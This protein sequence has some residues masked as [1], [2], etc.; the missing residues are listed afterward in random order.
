MKKLIPHLLS[1]FTT[2]R[3]A[4]IISIAVTVVFYL[5]S[6]SGDV[7]TYKLEYLLCSLVIL[8]I[9]FISIMRAN[10]DK[11]IIRIMADNITATET[12]LLDNAFDT[13]N[14]V[15]VTFFYIF[16]AGFLSCSCWLTVNLI[17]LRIH[18]PNQK[19]EVKEE[20]VLTRKMLDTLA[21]R[22]D[23][24]LFLLKELDKKE[25]EVKQAPVRSGNRL[26][27]IKK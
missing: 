8:F 25:K 3:C 19:N 4:T 18:P 23:S 24:I 20:F 21:V 7:V 22:Q 16:L 9:T 14:T 12:K 1:I 6:L 27:A 13:S 2:S 17:T 10:A 15:K 11:E 26:A 5:F